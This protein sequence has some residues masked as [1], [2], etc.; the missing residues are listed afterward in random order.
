VH[1]RLS[2]LRL[3]DPIF[4]KVGH[5]INLYLYKARLINCVQTSSVLGSLACSKN[6]MTIVVLFDFI[7]IYRAIQKIY[8]VSIL[9][10]LKVDPHKL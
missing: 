4:L 6:I 3:L 2:G 9:K 8:L 1:S 10:L 5:L 7:Q